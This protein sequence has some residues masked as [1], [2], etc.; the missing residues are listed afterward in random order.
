LEDNEHEIL[1]QDS[2]AWETFKKNRIMSTKKTP[3][4]PEK[5]SFKPQTNN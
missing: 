5:H 4:K 1:H 2:I 3:S